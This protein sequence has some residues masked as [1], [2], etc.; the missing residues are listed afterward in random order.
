M[1]IMFFIYKEQA[2]TLPVW[3]FSTLA[4]ST[5]GEAAAGRGPA[6]AGGA[7]GSGD[8]PEPPP[9]RV[10]VATRGA[11]AFPI[12]GRAS[13]PRRQP[14]R[15]SFLKGPRPREGGDLW[16]GCRERGGNGAESPRHP[17]IPKAVRGDAACLSF[18]IGAGKS[19]C[20]KA[21]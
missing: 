8:A 18:P 14:P 9:E 3:G 4:V 11:V 21:G 7:V 2:F 16:G 6:V 12:Y 20:P 10:L 13:L 5:D 15:K 1:L 17:P 19:S